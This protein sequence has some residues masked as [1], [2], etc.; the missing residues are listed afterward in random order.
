MSAFAPHNPSAP[1][2]PQSSAPAFAQAAP[3]DGGT[4]NIGTVHW[5]VERDL[6]K[7]P[8]YFRPANAF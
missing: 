1:V 2:T 4:V 3:K 7:D 8:S 5:H 6:K